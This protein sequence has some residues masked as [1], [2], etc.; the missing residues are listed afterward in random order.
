MH[1][2]TF[3][4]PIPLTVLL[5]SYAKPLLKYGKRMDAGENELLLRN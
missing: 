3:D 2:E 5:L 4:Y 1:I